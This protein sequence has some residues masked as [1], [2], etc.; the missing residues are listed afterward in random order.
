VR[1]RAFAEH[2]RGQV[3]PLLPAL[4]PYTH[5]PL[6]GLVALGLAERLSNRE[7]SAVA[8]SLL[9]ADA[10][11]DGRLGAAQPTFHAGHDVPP[12]VARR[13]PAHA[14]ACAT[15]SRRS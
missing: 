6:Q 8:L 12:S 9:T 11:E 3:L 2:V 13:G 7:L 5:D 10:G 15:E 14:L 1:R 4:M